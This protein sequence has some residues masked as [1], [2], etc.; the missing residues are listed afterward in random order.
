MTL[1]AEVSAII[2]DGDCG[3]LLSSGQ[4]TPESPD[5]AR[6]PDGGLDCSQTECGWCF[7]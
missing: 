2:L 4:F 5:R 7:L 1:P 3:S 6:R